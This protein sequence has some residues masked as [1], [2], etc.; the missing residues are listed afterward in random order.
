MTNLISQSSWACCGWF[1]QKTF[2]S[3]PPPWQTGKLITTHA[4]VKLYQIY[5]QSVAKPKNKLWS[6][7]KVQCV[8]GANDMCSAEQYSSQIYF[9]CWLSKRRCVIGTFFWSS[10]LLFIVFSTR[11]SI[12]IKSISLKGDTVSRL[13]LTYDGSP[14]Q[15]FAHVVDK[16]NK[17]KKV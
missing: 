11:F 10:S 7:G 2:G 12:F 16:D 13:S 3:S 14:S 17:Q 1:L 6:I 15:E 5:L 9:S 8:S 4:G